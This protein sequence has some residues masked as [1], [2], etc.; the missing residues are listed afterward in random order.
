MTISIEMSNSGNPMKQSDVGHDNYYLQNQGNRCSK[1]GKRMI[2]YSHICESKHLI[3]NKNDSNSILC[4]K[5]GKI[6]IGTHKCK[7]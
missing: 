5:C 7:Y 3:K 1:C 6:K 4:S 2:G